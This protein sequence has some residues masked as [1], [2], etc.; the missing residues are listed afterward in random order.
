MIR[1]IHLFI[2]YSPDIS[3]TSIVRRLKQKSTHELWNSYSGFLTKHFWKEHTLWSE[4]YLCILLVKP[5]LI[6]YANILKIRVNGIH[7]ID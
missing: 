6:L 1:D 7:P 3:I 2:S 5:I 4:S